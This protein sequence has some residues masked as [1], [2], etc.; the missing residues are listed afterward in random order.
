[1][2]FVLYVTIHRCSKNVFVDVFFLEQVDSGIP[3]EYV[4]LTSDLNG[5]KGAL[6]SLRQFLT[7]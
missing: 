2:S 3:T 6:S 7:L 4:L 5:F 1:M